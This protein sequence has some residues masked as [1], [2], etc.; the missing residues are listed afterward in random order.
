[1][2]SWS[3]RPLIMNES[4]SNQPTDLLCSQNMFKVKGRLIFKVTCTKRG[5][6]YDRII[7]SPI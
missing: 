4:H 3:S 6:I 2:T 5:V 7:A 1:M